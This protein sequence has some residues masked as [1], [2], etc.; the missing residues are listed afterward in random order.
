MFKSVIYTIMLRKK[1]G[2][3][4]VRNNYIKILSNYKKWLQLFLKCFWY[5][6]FN[7]LIS[8]FQNM[9]INVFKISLY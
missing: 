5:F 6:L 7:G 8:K 9:Y 4:F 1:Q 2:I 3:D